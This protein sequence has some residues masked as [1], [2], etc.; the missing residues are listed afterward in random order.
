M[1]SFKCGL[2]HSLWQ[3][4]PWS[5]LPEGYFESLEA[6]RIFLVLSRWVEFEWRIFPLRSEFASSFLFCNFLPKMNSHI[7][8]P[9][10]I[11]VNLDAFWSV[12]V[13]WETF[14]SDAAYAGVGSAAV[15]C[16]DQICTGLRWGWLQPLP[17]TAWQSWVRAGSVLR[18]QVQKERCGEKLFSMKTPFP[19]PRCNC[20][21]QGS[22]QLTAGCVSLY[23]AGSFCMGRTCSGPFCE[24]RVRRE[25]GWII[26]H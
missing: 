15:Q 24:G 26:N 4:Q 12:P 16:R 5:I 10:L 11:G 18:V 21:Y 6:I 2:Y 23:V 7:P 22:A 1:Q 25:T 19:C 17:E 3:G 14:E 20:V 9:Y 8:V 13:R